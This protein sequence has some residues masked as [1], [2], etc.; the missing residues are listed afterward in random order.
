VHRYDKVLEQEYIKINV[1]IFLPVLDVLCHQSE[2]KKRVVLE[3]LHL[4]LRI[5]FPDV[6]ESE[7]MDTVGVEQDR[8]ILL[9]GLKLNHG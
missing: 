7:I 5:P 4:I 6:A 9:A 1:L 3:G 2:T 8:E